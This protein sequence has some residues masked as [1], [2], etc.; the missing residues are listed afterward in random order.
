[1]KNGKY[2]AARDFLG[3]KVW[4][5]TKTQKPVVSFN[6]NDNMKTKLSD[7]F[8]KDCLFD[9]FH[10]SCSADSNT[11]LTGTYNNSFHLLDVD[12]CH[13]FQYELNYKKTTLV[14]EVTEDK[15]PSVA[16]MNYLTKTTACHFDKNRNSMAVSSLNCFFIYSM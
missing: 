5:L 16:K 12:T 4:D 13:N 8:E 6:L 10:L 2:L 11:I 14:K 7:M 1:M 3:V 9:K 15:L